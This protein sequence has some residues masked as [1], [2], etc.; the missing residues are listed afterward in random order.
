MTFY[1]HDIKHDTKRCEIYAVA[2]GKGVDG[3][4]TTGQIKPAKNVL[5]WHERP[6]AVTRMQQKLR[7]PG[8]LQR[9]PRSKLSSP[10]TPPS[11]LGWKDS[12]FGPSALASLSSTKRSLKNPGYA[13]ECMLKIS[14]VYSMES[15][16]MTTERSRE[17]SRTI[18]LI[19][20]KHI[21]DE[22]LRKNLSYI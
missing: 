9:Y 2:Y 6:S 16:K 15:K 1:K 20:T 5:K 3:V 19:D 22:K 18:N 12:S 17:N 14:L 21:K 8:R 7:R 4:R 11:L 13:T 10:R